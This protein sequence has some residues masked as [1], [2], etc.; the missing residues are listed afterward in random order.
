MI[1]HNV[2]EY[3]EICR[4]LEKAG[5][6]VDLLLVLYDEPYLKVRAYQGSSYVDS[7]FAQKEVEFN[8]FSFNDERR[9][10]ELTL[11]VNACSKC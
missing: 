6:S 8:L 10:C 2:N 9:G 7:I 11:F 1:G 5:V 3:L 4:N